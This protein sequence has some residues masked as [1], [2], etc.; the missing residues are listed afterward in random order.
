MTKSRIS[1]T[2]FI[3]LT[4]DLAHEVVKD[5]FDYINDYTDYRNHSKAQE[6]FE[7]TY[8]LFQSI[9]GEYL[10]VEGRTR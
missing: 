8:D 3:S 5:K 1:N 6:L 9:V 2:H 7:K 4:A 10:E